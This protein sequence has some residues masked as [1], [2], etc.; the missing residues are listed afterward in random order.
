V[1]LVINIEGLALFY[2][3]D[4]GTDLWMLADAHH[5]G[6]IETASGV[7]KTSEGIL[8]PS[9]I[10]L[11]GWGVRI[12]QGANREEIPENKVSMPDP[13][14]DG[15]RLPRVSDFNGGST[16]I[17]R[18]LLDATP[19]KMPSILN[20][21]LR[22]RGGT[23]TYQPPDGEAKYGDAPWDF[24]GGKVRLLTHRFRYS[25]DVAM[26]PVSL[27]FTRGDIE[28]W[29]ELKPRKVNGQLRVEVKLAIDD[30]KGHENIEEKE[31]EKLAYLNEWQL[32]HRCFVYPGD[33]IPTTP[34]KGDGGKSLKQG[35][36][37]GGADP[38]CPGGQIP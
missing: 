32:H 23:V 33:V 24:G 12:G 25:V 31:E 30:V 13:D 35:D 18:E 5:L 29:V 1:E 34:L 14:V 36:P 21:M 3:R 16:T 27:V 6:R 4:K 22:L 10:S 28:E 19:Q 17:R 2:N 15:Q 26:E 20:S 37:V 11:A 9:E 8:T 38:M 7:V